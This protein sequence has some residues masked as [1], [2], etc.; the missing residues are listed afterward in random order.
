MI[1]IK[2]LDKAVCLKALHDA[3]HTQ[4]MSS[5]GTYTANFTVDD[6]ARELKSNR[7]YIDY[8]NG[9][10]IKVDFHGDEINEVLYDRD[11]G[12]GACRKAIDSIR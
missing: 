3:S 2:G 4:G 11:C 5:L 7:D 10:V 8:C 9:R 6:A 12:A 1:S